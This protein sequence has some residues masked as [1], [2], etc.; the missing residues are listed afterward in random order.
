MRELN[1]LVYK[2]VPSRIFLVACVKPVA[3]FFT[4]K[5]T[6]YSFNETNH[7]LSVF[8]APLTIK[9]ETRRAYSVSM[10]RCAY[11]LI[12]IKTDTIIETTSNEHIYNF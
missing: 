6:L 10:H 9:C 5:L 11:Q 8:I 7:Q 1:A 4:A 2:H 12:G 3:S